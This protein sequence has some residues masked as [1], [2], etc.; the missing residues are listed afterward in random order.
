MY[1]NTTT[2]PSSGLL[3]PSFSKNS[4]VGRLASGVSGDIHV[5]KKY[6]TLQSLQKD[7]FISVTSDSKHLAEQTYAKYKKDLENRS[8]KVAEPATIVSEDNVVVESEIEYVDNGSTQPQ[9]QRLNF[10][11][12]LNDVFFRYDDFVRFVTDKTAERV[13]NGENVSFKLPANGREYFMSATLLKGQNA[14]EQSCGQPVTSGKTP[15]A[16]VTTEFDKWRKDYYDYLESSGRKFYSDI[17]KAEDQAR[18]GDRIY[19]C[20]GTDAVNK[21]FDIV[22]I[23]YGNG[24]D[25]HPSSDKYENFKFNIASPIMEKLAANG[26]TLGDKE[27]FVAS[28]GSDGIIGISQSTIKDG[29]KLAAIKQVLEGDV[30]LG[31]Q[32]LNTCRNDKP[33]RFIDAEI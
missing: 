9:S 8:N 5:V 17:S 27:G 15:T 1:F 18:F 13:A 30:T 11:I 10:L 21:K 31:Q 24:G 3:S 23:S 4:I 29:S 28:I 16:N 14:N 6:A 2:N 26:I 7:E 25:I 19:A 33:Y 32:L 20:A 12:E 22:I